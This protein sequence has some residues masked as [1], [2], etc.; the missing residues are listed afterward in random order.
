[1]RLYFR[2]KDNK[3]VDFEALTLSD[4]YLLIKEA[5]LKLRTEEIIPITL[6]GKWIGMQLIPPDNIISLEQE[7]WKRKQYKR[8]GNVFKLE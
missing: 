6:D 7:R 2:T 3:P 4:Q 1:M 8:V 5:Q